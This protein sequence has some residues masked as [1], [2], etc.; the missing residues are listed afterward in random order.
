MDDYPVGV[1][2]HPSDTHPTSATLVMGEL[3]MGTY[4]REP[5]ESAIEF[6]FRVT[7]DVFMLTDNPDPTRHQNT[8]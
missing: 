5:R 2:Y 8:M 4:E 6:V 3:E 7:L 1:I